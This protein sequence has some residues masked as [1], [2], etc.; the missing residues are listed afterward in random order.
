MPQPSNEQP[1]ERDS[2]RTIVLSAIAVRDGYNPRQH[3]DPQAQTR[4]EESIRYHGVL[5]ALTV[6]GD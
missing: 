5:T 4:L 6:R 3:R 1:R 2:V